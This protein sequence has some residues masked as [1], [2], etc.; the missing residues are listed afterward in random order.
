MASPL[1]PREIF[2]AMKDIQGELC[3]KLGFDLAHADQNTRIIARSSLGVCALIVFALLDKATPAAGQ[4]LVTVANLQAAI[5][6]AHSNSWPPE[7]E[8]VPWTGT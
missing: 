8:S 3:L 6:A 7:P 4:P 2:D 1:T 5:A